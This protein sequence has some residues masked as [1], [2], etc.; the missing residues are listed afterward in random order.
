MMQGTEGKGGETRNEFPYAASFLEKAQLI[1]SKKQDSGHGKIQMINRV[2]TFA[3]WCVIKLSLLMNYFA[4]ATLGA[5]V[6]FVAADVLGRYV[7]NKPIRGDF[8]LIE[9]MTGISVAFSLPYTLVVDHHVRIEIFTSRFSRH[10]QLIFDV[11]AYFFGIVV[12][13]LATYASIGYANSIRLGGLVIGVLPIPAY[14]FVY[15]MIFTYVAF[16]LVF[17]VKFVESLAWCVKK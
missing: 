12:F 14:P 8:E 5:M 2:V 11:L 4:G 15:L 10:A 6:L 1:L 16:T 7:L 17:L 3:Q 9:V 13:S